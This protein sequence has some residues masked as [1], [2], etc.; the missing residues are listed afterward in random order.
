MKRLCIVGSLHLDV[1]VNAENL[2]KQDET[3]IGS[4]VSYVFGG[5]GGNQALA[6]DY[7]GADVDFIGRVGTDEFGTKLESVINNGSID[8]SQ[9]QRDNGA[10]G[11]SVAIIDHQGE[12]GAV[13]VSEANLR[14]DESQMTIKKNTGLLL[15]QNEVT[16]GINLVASQKAIKEGSEVWLNAAP[17][18]PLEQELLKNLSVIILNRPE[19]SFYHDLLSSSKCD[20]IIKILTKGEQ[21]VTIN[22]P[23]KK[24]CH[25]DAFPVE[26]LSSHGAG[27]MFIGALAAR[28]LK[29]DSLSDSIKYAQAAAAIKVSSNVDYEIKTG[30]KNVSTFL[31]MQSN[32]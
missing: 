31:R 4:K 20:H 21:G 1:V 15:L 10:S 25:Y 11:M 3:V 27:D 9:L 2:P 17:T 16:N 5:K 23:N 14:I 24:Q 12:Y 28:Y 7:H 32:K 13:I 8:V 22:Y 18:R 29:N 30:D 6:A 26:K 19:A